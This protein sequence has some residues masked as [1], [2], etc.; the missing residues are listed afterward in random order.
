MSFVKTPTNL[1]LEKLE[2]TRLREFLEDEGFKKHFRLNFTGGLVKSREDILFL[3]GKVE[4]D[5]D[6]NNLL[7][8]KI[9]PILAINNSGDILESKSIQK[10]TIPSINTWYWVKISHTYSNIEEGIFSID[11]FGNLTGEGSNFLT[12]LRQL[13]NFPTKI[14]FKNSQYNT[15][16]YQILEVIDDTNAKLN[17]TS[18]TEESD[19]ELSIVGTFTPGIIIP[20][21]DKYPFNFDSVNIELIPESELNTPPSYIEGENFFLSRLR[22]LDNQLIIQ[23]KRT[24]FIR[25]SFLQSSLRNSNSLIGVESVRN[26][27]TNTTNINNIVDIA[28]CM[29]SSNWAI[30]SSKNIV[31][32]FGSSLGGRYKSILDFTDG[33]FNNWRLYT[34]NGQYCRISSSVKKGNAINLLVDILDVDNYSENGGLTFLEQELLITPD[35]D[36]IELK[37][38][39]PLFINNYTTRFLPINTPIL[40]QE[41]LVSSYPECTYRIEYRLL[42]NGVFSEF[43]TI[44]SDQV[45]GYYNE[46]SFDSTGNLKE[47][48]LIRVKYD[49]TVEGGFITLTAYSNNFF[50]LRERIDINIEQTSKLVFSSSSNYLNLIPHESEQF[51]IIDNDSFRNISSTDVF[52]LNL[53]T[54][55][56]VIRNGSRFTLIIDKSTELRSTQ[57]N[58]VTNFNSVTGE[59]DVL[60][61]ITNRD[62]S[63]AKLN[64]QDLV[65]DF[66]Y[67]GTEW[68]CLQNYKLDPVNEIKIFSG[69]INSYF[70]TSGIGKYGGWLGYALCNGSNG[71][72]NLFDEFVIEPGNSSR[73]LRAYVIK[74]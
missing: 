17:G 46:E 14:R 68:N 59:G 48:G 11:R 3:N 74:I 49:S 26:T 67:D 36:F 63:Y 37:F 30:D 51:Q 45:H 40:S 20:E 22:I 41:L 58:I 13:P 16:E 55:E 27:N 2:L 24:K 53:S 29:R 72:P 60:K 69:D 19:L 42:V 66:L 25:N 57:I 23:D 34:S 61:N 18:F 62:S 50:S 52:F 32:I 70:D 6:S 8:I 56:D 47:S 12:I 5:I 35:A 73:Y 71:T 21:V 28:W 15:Q 1:F 54:S 44:P 33:D 38:V 10:F 39:D 7:T 64:E 9:N 4:Q 65:I 43:I 31:T